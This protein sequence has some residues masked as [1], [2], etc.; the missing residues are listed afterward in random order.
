MS[1]A[2]LQAPSDATP[3]GTAASRPV[4]RWIVSAWVDQ[5]LILLTPLLAI[6]AVMLLSSRWVGIKAE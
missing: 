5:L 2:T 6:P 1:A 4:R 3:A